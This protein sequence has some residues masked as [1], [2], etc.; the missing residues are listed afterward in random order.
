M[1]LYAWKG[2]NTAGKAVTGTK[3]AD[4]AKSLRQ[5][6]RRDGIFITEHREVL[7]AGG[8]KGPT[9]ANAPAGEKVSLLKREI[10]LKG[11]VERVRPQEVAAFTRQLATLLKAGIPLAEALG[12]LSEQADNKK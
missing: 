12:A 2:L 5:S 3:D 10:D 8:G 1:P 11:L 9:R 6:L 4:G 7:S